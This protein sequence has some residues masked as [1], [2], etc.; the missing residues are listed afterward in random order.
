[1]D[2]LG[3]RSYRGFKLEQ[4]WTDW[5]YQKLPELQTRT[6]MDRLGTRSYRGF[7]LEQ[8]WTDWRYQKLPGLQTRTGMDRLEVPG[9]TGASNLN[10]HGQTG[11][12]RS[13]RGFQLEQAWTDW[14]Y[15]EL[16]EFQ[17]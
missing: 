6:G 12:T 13:Y 9:A 4:A 5:R 7:K 10:R 8:A 14:R 1:M 2:R 11:G 15:Q 16:P 3:T 17:I